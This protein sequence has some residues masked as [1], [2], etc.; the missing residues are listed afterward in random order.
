[1]IGDYPIGQYPPACLSQHDPSCMACSVACCSRHAPLAFPPTKSACTEPACLGMCSLFELYTHTHR[2][3]L[4]SA[5]SSPT[6][7]ASG[8]P[9]PYGG[10]P[11]SRPFQECS[12][13]GCRP[14]RG[15]TVPMLCHL[16]CCCKPRG[17][18]SMGNAWSGTSTHPDAVG[19]VAHPP[20]SP[21]SGQR[22]MHAHAHARL[23][24]DASGSF[25]S[26]GMQL[27]PCCG[28]RVAVAQGTTAAAEVVGARV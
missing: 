25:L 8:T 13:T 20:P 1:M 17:T 23:A 9:N 10:Q 16:A 12:T 6:G 4:L 2:A 11:A 28:C 24:P 15:S 7:H 19:N 27:P 14:A 22:H 21:C 3:L 5:V 18:P 26:K